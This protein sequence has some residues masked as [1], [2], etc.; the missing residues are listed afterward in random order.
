MKKLLA[1]LLLGALVAC[2]TSEG[3]DHMNNDEEIES[4]ETFSKK[5]LPTVSFEE[6]E[7]NIDI[8]IE[9]QTNKGSQKILIEKVTKPKQ[10]DEY[11]FDKYIFYVEGPK[12]SK[13]TVQTDLNIY[14]VN[15][16]K[17]LDFEKIKFRGEEMLLASYVKND[18]E[19][20]V[21]VWVLEGDRL[22]DVTFNGEKAVTSIPVGN[23]PLKVL[24]NN[25]L[26]TFT[27]KD[28]QKETE[29]VFS[30]WSYDKDQYSFVLHD[31]KR[32]K[33]E[34][35]ERETGRYV[36]EK[37]LTYQDYFIDF[38]Y[39]TFTEEDYD[40]LL[41]GYLPD[42][43]FSLGTSINNVIENYTIF[44]KDF[45]DGGPYYETKDGMYFYNESTKMISVITISGNRFKNPNEIEEILGK[46]KSSGRSDMY[47]DEIFSI[48]DW[49]E[50]ML[51][52]IYNENDEL[53]R[54]ELHSNDYK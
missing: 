38:P 34:G 35:E 49:D 43:P 23:L 4:T 45:Y 40:N 42:I 19:R 51:W 12:S 25:Y 18:K 16:T 41:K 5:T 54:M 46:P 1:V 30:T 32:Y 36:A 33:N 2:N 39:Y 15:L 21:F 11:I 13:V 22:I 17:D 29:F 14:E 44:E 37:W 20:N 52:L 6:I 7:K 47:P 9:L 3:L 27:Y 26:Q 24:K 50:Y 28:F 31:E 53:M 8:E 48:Y 10:F